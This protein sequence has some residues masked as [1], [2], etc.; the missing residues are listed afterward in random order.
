MVRKV[1]AFLVF[2]LFAATLPALAQGTAKGKQY[3]IGFSNW[4][5]RFEFYQELERGIKETAAKYGVSLRV[6][7]P[8]GD[9]ATQQSEIENF[10]AQKVDAL[11]MV[12]VDSKAVIPTIEYANRSKVPVVTVDIAAGGGNVVT[13]IASDNKL[14]GK[15]AADRMA[16][17]LNGRGKI[18]LITFRQITSTIEREQ[19]FMDEIKKFP[20]IQVVASQTGDSQRDKAMSLTEDY[21]SK[22]P[23]LKGIFAVNDMQGLG[24]LAAAQAANK[25]DIAIIGFDASAEA[26]SAMKQGTPYIG[27]VAQ[28]PYLLGQYAVESA[29]KKLQGGK[30]EANIPVPVKMETP[31]TLK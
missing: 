6:A 2:L 23:D 4:S 26:V 5:K 20:N 18:A 25:K 12:P 24:A 19:G 16:E 27:S 28:Q 15:L 1:E 9:Q 31:E 17:V 29:L 10:I 14:G 7:D 22:Y 30:V 21:L 13:F 11:I 3:T 8:N